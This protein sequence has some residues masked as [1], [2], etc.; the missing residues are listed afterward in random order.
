MALPI[1]VPYT[2][3][4]ATTAIPLSN[5]DSDY[6]TVYQ[7]VNG[8]GNGSVALA[9]VTITGGTVS[10]VS[11]V[12]PTPF[13]ANGVVYASSTSA[14]TTGS[15]LVFDGSNLGLGFTPNA[16]Y[17]T[18]KALQLGTTGQSAIAGY[19]SGGNWDTGIYG[20]AALTGN[21]VYVA[22]GYATRY[23]QDQSGA[24][25][26]YTAASGTAGGTITFTQAMSLDN[27]GRLLIGLTSP[28]F[29]LNCKLQ[30]YKADG[31]G[32]SAIGVGNNSGSS[33]TTMM[34][35]LNGNG[36]VGS[37]QTSGSVTLYNTTSDYRLKT[38]VGPVADAGQRIDVLR[39]VEYTWN[40]NGERTRGFLA[41]QFQEV[42]ANSVSG[43]KDAVDAKGKP[44][45][46]AMQAG[47]SEV[48][49]DLVAEIQSL[50]KRLNALESK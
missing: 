49:A 16:W 23:G 32:D 47:S 42:Y 1:T 5:L 44:V 21:Y 48:I 11:G 14:L 40:S 41:H 8:I 35:F 27:N 39:P 46:Q 28:L 18:A 13:T 33:A 15:A 38:V 6:A 22:N 31:A 9:N 50:R 17:A 26:W 45:Y 10:N 30:V 4:N 37:I 12:V 19:A 34:V 20:N 29:S 7:A 24:H 3:G 2:F 43:T 36:T 25:K